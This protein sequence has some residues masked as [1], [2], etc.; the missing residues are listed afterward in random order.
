MPSG[1]LVYAFDLQL[2]DPVVRILAVYE[3]SD[4]E[5]L[6]AGIQGTQSI[7]HV[8][9]SG[10]MRDLEGPWSIRSEESLHDLAGLIS[11]GIV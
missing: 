8:R 5:H 4:H 1:F 7:F 2:L 6:P 9:S 10:L 3:D 11:A